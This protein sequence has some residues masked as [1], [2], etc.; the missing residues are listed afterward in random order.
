MVE[1]SDGGARLVAWWIRGT[2]VLAG[3]FLASILLAQPLLLSDLGLDQ[4][5]TPSGASNAGN[6]QLA[7]PGQ[8]AAPENVLIRYAAGQPLSARWV[9]R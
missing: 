5:P 3:L 1:P 2:V 8:D 6:P 4:A 7:A 9:F